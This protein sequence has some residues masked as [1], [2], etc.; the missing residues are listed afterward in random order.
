MYSSLGKVV[1]QKAEKAIIRRRVPVFLARGV[2]KLV[3]KGREARM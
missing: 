1:A 3:G 2:E